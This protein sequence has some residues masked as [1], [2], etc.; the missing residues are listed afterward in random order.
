MA[1]RLY[2]AEKVNS[3]AKAAFNMTSDQNAKI[4]YTDL[5]H[6]IKTIMTHK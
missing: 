5:K 3:L 6:K 1:K 4:P 2:F